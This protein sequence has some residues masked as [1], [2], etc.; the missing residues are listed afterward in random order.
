MASAETCHLNDAHLPKEGSIAAFKALLPE[1]K[2]S[3]IHLRHKHDKH[4]PEYFITV[5]DFSDDELTHFTVS[6]LESVR[7]G[8]T[9]VSYPPWIAINSWLN[10][11][12]STDYTYLGR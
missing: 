11:P 7:V 2:T 9:D 4:E 6:D 1:I 5:K 10:K 12:N 8:K 3:L